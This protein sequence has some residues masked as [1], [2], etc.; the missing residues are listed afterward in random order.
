M[1]KADCDDLARYIW[2]IANTG[3]GIGTFNIWEDYDPSI[4]DDPSGCYR[5]EI[6]EIADTKMAL[7]VYYGGG[8]AWAY[9]FGGDTDLSCLR[10][11]LGHVFSAL[12]REWFWVKE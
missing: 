9:E 11:C 7:L 5:V 12:G 3:I 10:E 8:Y 2:N 1:F 6:I 4:D